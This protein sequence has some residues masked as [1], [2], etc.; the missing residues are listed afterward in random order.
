[1]LVAL[2][3]LVILMKNGDV[4]LKVGFAIPRSITLTYVEEPGRRAW[5]L[6]A[7]WH[8]SVRKAQKSWC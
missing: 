2:A 3:A 6:L 4:A 8:L 1:M 5:R 7:L